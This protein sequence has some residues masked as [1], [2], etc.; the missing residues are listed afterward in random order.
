LE[1]PQAKPALTSKGFAMPLQSILLRGDAKLEAAATSDLAHIASG[2]RGE[3]VRKIQAALNLLDNAGLVLDGIYGTKTA[4]AVLE[5]KRKRGIVNRNVQTT[6]DNIVGRMT[7]AALDRELSAFD[8][9][10]PLRLRDVNGKPSGFQPPPRSLTSARFSIVGFG[11]S[12]PPTAISFARHA[13]NTVGT[14]TC[15]NT[16]LIAEAVCTNL[17]DPAFDPPKAMS[18]RATFLSDLKAP[19]PLKSGLAVT[20]GGRVP[21]TSEPSVMRLEVLHPGD[22]VIE[23]SRIGQI[24]LLFIAVRQGN[25]GKVGGQPLTKLRPKTQLVPESRF[26]SDPAAQEGVDPENIFDGRPVN[27][28]RGGRLINLGGEGETPEFEDYQVDLSHSLGQKGGFRPW[29]DD[30]DPSVFIPDKSASH[31]TMRGVPLNLNPNFAK[32]IKRIAAPGCL[33]TFSGDVA[34]E[35]VILPLLKGKPLESTLG[36]QNS[37]DIAG[38][39]A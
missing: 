19:I 38:E 29:T 31:I 20:D 39:V 26:F 23:A 28:K 18:N 7:M 35:K 27:P 36:V 16:F 34:N 33:L 12:A 22:A 32:V 24:R 25:K 8:A 5:F 4:N 6:A 14:V 10:R 15:E 3:H 9:S 13:P 1:K 2:Q 17:N 11:S 37:I 21:L 30:S